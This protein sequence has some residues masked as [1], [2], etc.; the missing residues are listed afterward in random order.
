MLALLQRTRLY[1]ISHFVDSRNGNAFKIS[2]YSFNGDEFPKIE[3]P[4][5]FELKKK[6]TNA[7][8]SFN[9]DEKRGKAERGEEWGERG[10]RRER[11][12]IR[13]T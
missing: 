9:G 3:N 1:N 12:S 13:G 7:W 11:K 8:Q 6:K 2:F 5:Y 10:E 4:N